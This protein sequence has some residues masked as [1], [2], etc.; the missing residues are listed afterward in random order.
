M[1]I[2]A[3]CWLPPDDTGEGM[4]SC[5]VRVADLKLGSAVTAGTRNR[6]RLIL[7]TSPSI[8]QIGGIYCCRRDPLRIADGATRRRVS[9]DVQ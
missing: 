9:L 1:E 5:V 6:G 7:S 4:G 3:F 2:E 8:A